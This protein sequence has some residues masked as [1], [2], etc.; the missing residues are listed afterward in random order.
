MTFASAAVWALGAI[1]LEQF[2]LGLT[3]AGR[4]GAFYDLVSRTACKALAY[5]ILFFGI[6]R[7]HEPET[8]IR[9]VL[10]LR[11]PSFLA[12]IFAIAV[13]A[14]LAVPSEWLAEA[15]DGRFPHPPQEQEALDRLYSIATVGKR[16]GLVTTLVFLQPALDA[17][18]FQGA[19]FTPLRRSRKA[20]AVIFATAAF[21]TLSNASPRAMV[22]LLVATLVFA[23]IRGATGSI[24]PGMFAR[25]AFWS[26]SI[27]PTMMLGRDPPAPTKVL[28][29]VSAAVA[30]AAL[31][32]LGF[33]SRRDA[34]LV[35][36]KLEDGGS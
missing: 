21:E 7:L 14:A 18:L 3:E 24:F 25:M 32:G 20:E 9:H 6:L 13:G 15:I 12:M 29:G 1:F 17:L 31:L 36:A 10:A 16:V 33:L 22:L 11:R 28:L 30:V 26:V 23:W 27:V 34:R 5:S 19:L 35:D 8:S 4:E 2:L